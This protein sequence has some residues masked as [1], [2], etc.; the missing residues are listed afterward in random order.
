MELL[1]IYMNANR[2]AC[3][4]YNDQPLPARTAITR[5]LSSS[6][7]LL[8]SLKQHPDGRRPLNLPTIP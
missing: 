5:F 6:F 2:Y 7:L 8:G 1:E 4:E 3:N